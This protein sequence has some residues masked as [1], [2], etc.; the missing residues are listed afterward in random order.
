M[1]NGTYKRITEI[2]LDDKV[3]QIAS[4]VIDVS[5]NALKKG[6]EL[7][8][9]SAFIFHENKLD[10]MLNDQEAP[11]ECFAESVNDKCNELNAWARMMVFVAFRWNGTEQEHDEVIEQMGTIN[12]HEKSSEMFC[13]VIETIDKYISGCAEIISG[14]GDKRKLGKLCWLVKDRSNISEISQ[15]QKAAV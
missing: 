12:Y 2:G 14:K 13:I 15:P 10:W 8:D 6:A 11:F 3:V 1:K 5:R 9:P 4:Q 7:N